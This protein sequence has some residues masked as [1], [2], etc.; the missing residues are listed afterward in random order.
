MKYKITEKRLKELVLRIIGPVSSSHVKLP[1]LYMAH[2]Y[3]RFGKEIFILNP[4]SDYDIYLN[5]K[6]FKKLSSLIPVKKKILKKVLREIISDMLA[7]KGLI[8]KGELVMI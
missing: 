3:D 2:F 5:K 8:P 6:F 4:E 1:R 7:T